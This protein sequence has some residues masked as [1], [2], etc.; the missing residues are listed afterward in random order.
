MDSVKQAAQE[1]IYS[2]SDLK[3]RFDIRDG[4]IWAQHN[5]SDYDIVGDIEAQGVP[6]ED[7]ILAFHSPFMRQFMNDYAVA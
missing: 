4:K 1:I 7:I 3:L 2:L 6:K 5:A